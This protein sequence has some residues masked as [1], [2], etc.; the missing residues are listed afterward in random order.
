[1]A[2]KINFNIQPP[3]DKIEMK[4]LIALMLAFSFFTATANADSIVCKG[5]TNDPHA[6]ENV[7]FQLDIKPDNSPIT[8]DF[9]PFY[10]ST[11]QYFYSTG[12]AFQGVDLTDRISNR[13]NKIVF[14]GSIAGQ[15]NLT[16]N[17]DPQANFTG[18]IL[19]YDSTVVNQPVQCQTSGI[20]PQRFVCPAEAD[21]TPSLVENLKTSAST[22]EIE[23]AIECGANVNF[24]DK[25]GCTP[26]MF[27]LDSTCGERHPT[28]Y[29]S[30]FSKAS[31]IVDLLANSGAIFNVTD[32]SGETPLIKAV[33]ASVKNVYSS[34]VAAEADFDAQDKNGNTALML[35]TRNGDAELVAQLLDGNPDRKLKN[36]E[37]QTAYDIAK[38][39]QRPDLMEMVQIADSTVAI[40]GSEDGTCSPLNIQLKQGQVVDLSLK[41]TAK[42]FRLELPELNLE[43]MAD[44]N[45]TIKKTVAFP[46]KGSFKFTCGFHGSTSLSQGVITVQ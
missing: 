17:Y 24:A 45:T 42:M 28:R 34:F 7:P 43:L 19:N 4:N 10:K 13:I 37:G 46:N 25:N 39:W 23:T 44:G 21:R 32:K 36:K 18:A 40:V 41:S 5:V 8:K 2:L 6:S 38:Q 11:M 29:T 35:A 15:R 31:E 30:T 9:G 33:N 22:D 1:M 3:K 12:T 26:L 16:F 14:L 27:A 20:L